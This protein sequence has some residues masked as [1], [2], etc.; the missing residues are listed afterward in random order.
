MCDQQ[1]LDFVRGALTAENVAGK[2]VLEVGSLDVNGSARAILE[3]LGPSDYT[4]VDIAHGPGV[5]VICNS[6]K[7]VEKFGAASF[8]VVVSTE[9]L[10]HVQDW[11]LVVSNLKNDTQ[12]AR[13]ARD[14]DPT[15]RLSIPRLSAR[16][17]AV[18]TRRLSAH[19]SRTCSIR[20][21]ECDNASLGIFLVA[22]RA[23]VFKENNLSDHAL[24]S[25]FERQA[26]PR[27]RELGSQVLQRQPPRRGRGSTR[28]SADT[29][30]C[31][32]RPCASLRGNIFVRHHG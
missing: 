26:D 10:E 5:D 30:I 8:D 23:D 18:R 1:C 11:R 17:L 15:H 29:R 19:C 21:L 32:P 22:Q 12:A 20:R 25:V 27:T 31:C 14:H 24:Y 3:P 7:L 9:M 2:R 28:T 6:E 4:G 13:H 16:L